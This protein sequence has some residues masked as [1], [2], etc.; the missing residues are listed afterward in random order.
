MNPQAAVEEAQL[1]NSSVVGVVLEDSSG[2][3]VRVAVARDEEG[4]LHAIGDICTHADVPLSEG[5]VEDC[6]LEC[7]GHGSYFDLRTG[8]PRNLPA[9]EAVPV[10]PVSVR[11]GTVYVDVDNPLKLN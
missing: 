7:W 5:D 9:V 3:Q 8:Q 4:Q 2:R 11:E 1:G 10:Y 6:A